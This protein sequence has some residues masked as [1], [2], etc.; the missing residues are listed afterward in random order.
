MT[1][2]ILSVGTELL[3]G[4]IVNTDARDLSLALS[5]LGIDV[6]WHSVVGDNPA[7]LRQ[8]LAVAAGRADLIVTTGGLGPTCDDLTKQTVAEFFGKPLYFDARAESELRAF[9]AGRSM[10][11]NNLIQCALPEGCTPFYNTCGTAPGCGFE[12]ADG[13]TV[14]ILPGPP[15][16]MNAMLRRMPISEAV[17]KESFERL[18]N[19]LHSLGWLGLCDEKTFAVRSSGCW[20]QLRL[21]DPDSDEARNI[22]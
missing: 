13:H 14:V 15:K 12:T 10:T 11:E 1:A 5:G 21:V 20:T 2:E 7:R 9:F 17:K 22:P 8:A 18:Q 6:H 19:R 16:E 3:L 4:N